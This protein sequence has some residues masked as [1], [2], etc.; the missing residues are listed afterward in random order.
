LQS[1][2]GPTWTHALL[3]N[4]DAIHNM[5]DSLGCVDEAGMKLTTEQRG[6]PRP[7]GVC[8]DVGAV[9]GS[10]LQIFAYQIAL[11]RGLDVDQPR[12]LAKSVTVE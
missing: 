8:C 11:E 5:L 12:N 6:Y 1:N 2:G 10:G 4:S 3:P 9:S 7:V